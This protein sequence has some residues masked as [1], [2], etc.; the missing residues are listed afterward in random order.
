M[1]LTGEAGF[2]KLVLLLLLL[3]C[4]VIHNAVIN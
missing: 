3:I 4:V 1:S 2:K